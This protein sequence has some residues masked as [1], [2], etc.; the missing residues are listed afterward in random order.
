[1]TPSEGKRLIGKAIAQ[2]EVV[3][4]ALEEG[5]IVIATSTSTAYVFEEL[6]DRTIPNKGMFTAGVVV[7]KGCCIT[8]PKGRYK[9]QVIKKGEVTEITTLDLNKF[10]GKMG[11]KD[12]FIKGANAIDPFGQAGILLG[13]VGGG[14]IG[15]SWGYITANG[16]TTIIAAGLEK[17]V[18]I[19]LTDVALKTGIETVDRSL[20]MAVG[21][22]IV[23]GNIITEIEA[24]N[25]LTS[26]D[27]I[28]LGGGGIDGAEGSKI[29]VLEGDDKSVKATYDL[30]C[31]VK[32]EPHLKTKVQ[33]CGLCNAKCDYK[34]Q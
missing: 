25:M 27:A 1:L 16:I 20:G 12:V 34:K 8:D 2:M 17:L 33:T 10:L 29:F 15:H 5:T 28:P 7:E 6:L 23:N 30:I 21:M 4:N 26:V 3:Q 9:H 19:S 14:T 24:L 31:S 22:M 32:G 13:G 11:P 18:P